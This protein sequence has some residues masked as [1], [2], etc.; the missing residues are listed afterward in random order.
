MVPGR[1]RKGDWW[2]RNTQKGQR[3]GRREEAGRLWWKFKQKE[4]RSSSKS[5]TPCTE[6]PGVHTRIRGYVHVSYTPGAEQ[7]SLDP[8]N[9]CVVYFFLSFFL[10]LFF[11]LFFSVE[12]EKNNE[13]I[14]TSCQQNQ[15][16]GKP[17]ASLK[18]SKQVKGLTSKLP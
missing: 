4:I 13:D 12:T 10:L 8:P 18:A 5:L 16:S 11:N 17:S 15:N 6:R 2:C 7:Q 3:Q 9:K 14:L 1:Q